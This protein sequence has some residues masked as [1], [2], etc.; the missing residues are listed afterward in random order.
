MVL[1]PMRDVSQLFGSV[2]EEPLFY[3][4]FCTYGEKAARLSQ[5]T[6]CTSLRLLEKLLEEVLG[7]LGKSAADS[8]SVFPEFP[9]LPAVKLTT[10]HLP[11]VAPSLPP[12]GS[13]GS[14]Y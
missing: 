5:N 8:Q 1:N 9:S 6:G 14:L 4:P 3:H 12:R 11:L 10:E 2:E 13:W 7:S